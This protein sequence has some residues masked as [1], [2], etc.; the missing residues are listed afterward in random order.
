MG[1]REWD[2]YGL[3]GWGSY[4]KCF[5]GYAH[6]ILVFRGVAFLIIAWAQVLVPLNSRTLWKHQDN[7][8]QKCETQSGIRQNQLTPKH[9]LLKIPHL[10]AEKVQNR[11]MRESWRENTLCFTAQWCWL[12]EAGIPI[13]WDLSYFTLNLLRASCIGGCMWLIFF[14]QPYQN[15]HGQFHIRC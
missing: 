3:N 15:L 1:I 11:S 14:P 13:G 7:N 2:S 8:R 10:K 12:I 9:S 5:L 6:K 4:D